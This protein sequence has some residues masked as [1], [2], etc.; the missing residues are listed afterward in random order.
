MLDS[1]CYNA[2][3]LPRVKIPLFLQCLPLRSTP[4]CM[5][6]Q[7]TTARSMIRED[8]HETLLAKRSDAPDSRYRC[9]D[10]RID[11]GRLRGANRGS[12][13]PNRGSDSPNR[14]SAADCDTH[15]ANCSTAPDLNASSPNRSAH[16]NRDAAS[17]DQDT[18]ANETPNCN[19]PYDTARRPGTARP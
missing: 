2:G 7:R 6:E 1:L 5:S 15:S 10:G 11:T 9:G 8:R 13:S 14:S 18:D 16:R 3:N 17:A 4:T 19:C 12:D